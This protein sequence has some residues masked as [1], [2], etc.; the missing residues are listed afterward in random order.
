[1]NHSRI[2]LLSHPKAT[3]GAQ[4]EFHS[5]SPHHVLQQ[6]AAQRVCGF[7]NLIFCK[8]F[9]EN[10]AIFLQKTFFKKL[11]KGTKFY[12][13]MQKPDFLQLIQ[14]IMRIFLAHETPHF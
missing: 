2:T 6:Y 10:F 3:A 12:F 5:R 9:G 11:F 8:Y 14:N 13:N 7:A 1:M 4:T